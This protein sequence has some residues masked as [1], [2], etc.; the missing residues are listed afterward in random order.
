MD[1]I[2]LVEKKLQ[3]NKYA[4]V[5]K[6]KYTG[7]ATEDLINEFA[8]NG[9]IIKNSDISDFDT[10][11]EFLAVSIVFVKKESNESHD[12][13]EIVEVLREI[14]IELENIGSV[15]NYQL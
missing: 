14:K 4:Y 11:S 3:E 2:E 1:V 7:D 5:I 13:E 8:N 9:Y 15:L 6:G 10:H 12:K